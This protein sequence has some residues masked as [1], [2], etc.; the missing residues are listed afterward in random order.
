MGDAN[1]PASLIRGAVNPTN[2]LYYYGGSGS[3]AYLGVYNPNTQSAYRVGNIPGIGNQN[4]D[5]A[6]TADGQLIVVANAN[7][8]A[9]DGAVPSTPGNQTLNLGD[10]IAQLPAGTLGNGIAFGNSGNI[11]V[12]TSSQLIEIDLATG[13]TVNT[14]S[15]PNT[16]SGFTDLAS[17][18]FPNTVQLEKDIDAERFAPGD[19]FELVVDAPSRGNSGARLGA[20]TTSGNQ[21]G[22]QS[23]FAGPYITA[24]GEVL[25]LSEV[26]AGSTDLGY[27][28]SDLVCYDAAA[29][30]APVDVRG[31]AP[32]WSIDQP[33]RLVGS[34][35]VCTVTNTSL[36]KSLEL[37][38]VSDPVS[39]TAVNAGDEITY[40]VTAEN[41]GAVAMDFDV[42]DDLSDVLAH[43]T[44]TDEGY[45]A[46]II[47]AT[48]DTTPAENQPTVDGS[49]Q[50]IW[51]GNLGVGEAVTITYTVVVSSDA[52]GQILNN[53]ANASATPPNGG[54]PPTDPAEV[55][56]NHPVNVPGF[57]LNKSVSPESGAAVNPGDTLEYS[58]EASNTGGT[59]LTDVEV[60]DDLNELLELGSVDEGSITATINGQ[61]AEPEA[62]LEDGLL[63]WTGTLATDETLTITFEFT[64][65]AN[66]S[67][68]TLANS[69]SGT[70]T[71]PGGE[72]ITPP[73]VVVENPVNS[74]GFEL[75]KNA[76]PPSGERVNP[77]SE[78]TYTVTGSNTGQTPLTNVDVVDDLTGVLEHAELID[79]PT[80]TIDGVE[81]D[82][83]TFE[84]GVANWSGSLASG[85]E[86]VLSYTVRVNDDAQNQTL[87]NTASGSA[88]PP[89]GGDPIDP[90]DPDNPP[91]TEH[92]VNDPQIE[93]VKSGELSIDSENVSLGDV[94][95]YE[96]F[97]TNTGN[98]TL[99]DVVITD[100]LDGLS[101]LS[102]SWP[103]EVGVLAPGE[104]VTA[105]ATLVLTQEHIDN[106]LVHNTA[107]AEGT[108]PPVY[109]PE[110]PGT[111]TPQ[112]PVTEDST[113]VTPLDP[114]PSIDLTKSSQFTDVNEYP[115]A[116]DT[117]EYTLIATND[118]NVT[119]TGVS[120]TD[121]LPGLEDVSYNWENATEE[122]VLA[123]GET[124]V[125]TGTYT[126]TQQD[127]NAGAVLNVGSTEGT[128]PNVKD[129][130]DPEGPGVPAAPVNDEDP[131]TV[132][133]DR[134][135]SLSLEKRIADDQEFAEAGDTVVYEFVVTNDGTTSLSNISISDDLLGTDAQY[136]Y[137]WDESTAEVAGTLE[138]GDS[139]RAT[140]EYML[141]QADLDLGWVRNIA[142]AEGTPPPTFDPQ[143]PENPV[144]SDPVE[145][146]PA[147]EVT[148]LPPVPGL[149]LEKSSELVGDVAVGESVQYS[150]T[151]TNSGNVTLT[152]VSIT[153]P[154]VGLS[155]L[156]YSWPGEVGVLAPGES[157]TASATYVL[158]Q[159]DVDAGVVVNAATAEGT[160][161]PSVDPSDP[162]NPVPSDPVETPP[163][164]EVTVL[165][166]VPGI[167]LEKSSE[168]DG[169]VVAGESVT[170][171][172]E[173]MNTGNVT[174][175]G[176]SISDPLDGLSELVYS[177][178]GEV[179]VL[180][181]GESVTATASLELTQELINSGWVENEALASGVP[182]LTYNPE[183][184]ENPIQPD[185][186]TDDST[187]ITEL[188]SDPSIEVVK[189]GALAGQA[190]AGESVEYTFTI[191]NMGN[192]TLSDVVLQDPLLSDDL[193]AIDED[194][195]PGA[196]GV[197]NPGESVEASAFY[198][199]TQADVDAGS[200]VNLAAVEGTPPPVTD[201]SDPGN[202]VP[203][204]PVNDEDPATVVV[205]SG[206]ALQLQKSS[207]LVADVVA[208]ESVTYSFEATNTGNVTLSEVSISDPLE[209]LSELSYSWPG[210]VG[211]LA[212]GE[213]VTASATYVLTQ[214][215]VDRGWVQNVATAGGTPPNPEDPPVEAPP[216]E[217]VTVLPPVPGL[218]LE[219]SSELV[220]DVAVG[221]SVQYSFTATN[222]GNVTL[223]GVSITDPMVGLSELSYSW[224]GEVGVLAPGESVTASATYVLTQADVDAGVV[225]NAATAE[226]TPPPS[227][228]PSDPENPVPSDPVETPPAEEVTVLPP[229]PGISLEKSSELD[230]DVVAGESVTYS[231]E[232]MNTGNVT[233]TGVSISDPLD[234]LSELVY[235][236]PGEVGVLAP[237][238][239]VTATASLEL[240]QELI[241][242]GWVENEALA[243]GVPPLTYN[244]EDPENPIQPDPVTD[245]STVITELESD[246]SIEV[247]KSGALAGQAAAGESV[248][249]TFTIT[250]MG[251]V[252]LSDVVLQDPLLSDDLVAI[253]E[254]AWPGAVGVLNPGESVEASA[255]YELTQADVDAGSVVNLA[256]VEGTPP[257]VIDPSDPGN[258]VPSDPVNDE[259]PATVVIPSGPALQLQKSSDLVGD[260]VAGESVTYSFEATNTG[261]VTLSDV[262]IT[263]PLDGLSELSYSWP[264][265]VGVL[266]P[267]ESVTASA[268]YVLTQA[269]VDRGWVQNVATA[270]GTPPNPEDPPV[271]APPAEEVTVLPPVPGLELDKSSELVGDVAVGE[272]VQYSFTATNSGNVTLTGVSITDPMV[273]LSE[274]SYSWPGEVGVLAPGESVTASATYVLTQADVDAGVV[275]NAA[276]AEGT[277][278]PSVDP[279]DPENPVPSD[280]V[281][282]PPV[283]EVTVLPPV[284]G[285]S[286]EK[287][288]ELVGD[289][290]A[291]ESVT[292]S[293]EATNTGNVTL[294]DVV[295]T[296]P[297]V[298]L[299]ELSYSWPG[300]VGVL[301]PGESVTASATYVL[302]QADVD[303][304][305]VANTAWATGTPPVD[306]QHPGE[307]VSPL[308]PVDSTVTVPLVANPSI[309]LEKTGEFEGA[310]KVGNSVTF[311]FTG[312]NTGNV[313]LTDVKI[314]DELEGL[315]DLEYNWPSEPGVLTP[316]ESV[317]AS[318]SYRL[319]QADADSGE[320]HN[321]ATIWAQDPSGIP[322]SDD[323]SVTMKLGA[324]AVT[325]SSGMIIA[326]VLGSMLL[327][328]GAMLILMRN[329]RR[330]ESV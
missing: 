282:T 100:P 182:P 121:G 181:P 63:S 80:A 247:V 319:T 152:G 135:P 62:I 254:D 307:P 45:S 291:G 240:T 329:F 88:T 72:T 263:D 209:G 231:F 223:T 104:S 301:A 160:P 68:E 183:D 179:G 47:N 208:G 38:K 117:V 174:L 295:I 189:S 43:G 120:I 98:V 28:N 142:T 258:P 143:D 20:V 292:Y 243:S 215:D 284:P 25:N 59:P 11:F 318:A 271:E 201:P 312:T 90:V 48:G 89:G 149:E 171:S 280:P 323:D 255:F 103:G 15:N 141:T 7:V 94:I 35:V 9:V 147:E 300:E 294:S 296:D 320:V 293:F 217:E 134:D 69:A 283:E 321:I 266:A 188:E 133:V 112:D 256:A 176:V 18:G 289:V 144:P 309:D 278:P 108:P 131:E 327:L 310:A 163:A 302:T 111:P 33:D 24:N 52:A 191:T 234:G 76:N 305:E 127:I 16:A 40:T 195:W 70:A 259:D 137:Y 239:S 273:G 227:V 42:T 75:E 314:D 192:V 2:G 19:Q 275:V 285:I 164:E 225:V 101:D 220:G 313:T 228:D 54:T 53:A 311:N 140:A 58:I 277:P 299:S 145:A 178:P 241:N 39:G 261:N 203:S 272:S 198:E 82:G 213:S 210:E 173:A 150:F 286:L 175:T 151:A 161:P 96:F 4:G 78:I 56:T 93:L 177:W 36:G 154:M 200:V 279:S 303:A 41:T 325:G 184:P 211:V 95:D 146:P 122:G 193:V 115:S 87:T 216:A 269:D 64:V 242:S 308:P 204:D 165:P 73:D 153:D 85:E 226:G 186:V 251:N 276:T 109:N 84:D 252:T 34:T 248:E 91:T 315:G 202:P 46:S 21:T 237:G 148:V 105:T 212:P 129:P 207:D 132:L 218:E 156:S 287:S 190:A 326:L 330:K 317:E 246:P 233:L 71:P 130:E 110:D 281:E 265:E 22:R 274:L 74:P 270:G 214:A 290:V 65:G 116:G 27:Y 113:V 172:F 262:V 162:E 221:E 31:E 324:L 49:Q 166:P 205:P 250:N 170:Y 180:A 206:P 235:S 264:G 1:A 297:M 159:A 316:G 304:G 92:V 245:D 50:L 83:L 238:E 61:P 23:S 106:G 194:A 229:V 306:P 3:P 185:P 253:D 219:K 168:L 230:G 232:A 99:S 114:A 8:Y 257:P 26:G 322:V 60:N 224:P 5:F 10:P 81:V 136:T 86:L 118:G 13:Q 30:N 249:Y 169:D 197:L 199:L 260:V 158:T 222:S 267:G 138:P 55:T 328:L 12:S 119:L 155:E 51:G 107:T 125:L 79:G 29:G 44:I 268:T 32:N 298:G 236:W 66:A 139:V 128:P 77:G 288:S 124:V 123:P 196:V 14:Y 37:N 97:A 167:S 67:G 126:L 6:F 57:E 187:V 102:Y 244:P 157:V 17:C